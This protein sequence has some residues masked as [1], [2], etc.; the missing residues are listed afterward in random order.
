MNKYDES[1]MIKCA[2]STQPSRPRTLKK[3]EAKAKD[4][5]AEDRLPQGQGQKGLRPRT[6]GHV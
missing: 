2:A 5:V 6:R 3:S 4:R 1:V